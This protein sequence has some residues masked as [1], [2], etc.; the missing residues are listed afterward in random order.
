MKVV[1]LGDRLNDQSYKWQ[2]FCAFLNPSL[3]FLLKKKVLEVL[4]QFVSLFSLWSRNFSMYFN[5]LG[6]NWILLS[7]NN[8]SL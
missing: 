1:V 6:L 7:D 5:I 4:Q 3:N 8:R 2:S